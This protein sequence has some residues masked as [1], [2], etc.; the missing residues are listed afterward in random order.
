MKLL[1]ISLVP[2]SKAPNSKV[3]M[4][5]MLILLAKHNGCSEQE[6]QERLE[7]GEA[8]ST[9]F[10]RYVPQVEKAAIGASV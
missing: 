5:S 6:V 8:M 7:R 4:E 10:A 3:E 9:P 1:R 2:N